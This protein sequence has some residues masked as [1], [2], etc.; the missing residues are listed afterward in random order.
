MR[1]IW[2][3][4]SAR[5]YKKVSI[6]NRHVTRIRTCPIVFEEET[7]LVRFCQKDRHVFPSNVYLV[8]CY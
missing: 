3:L 7:N 2:I 5:T 4:D 6:I 8:K 1:K